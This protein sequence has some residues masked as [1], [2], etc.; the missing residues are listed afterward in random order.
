MMLLA[1]SNEDLELGLSFDPVLFKML[2]ILNAALKI[3]KKKK[4]TL[5]SI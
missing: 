3:K 4:E 5:V 1:L 2:S